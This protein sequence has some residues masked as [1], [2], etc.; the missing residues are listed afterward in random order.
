MKD[1]YEKIIIRN[2]KKIPYFLKTKPIIHLEQNNYALIGKLS[3]SLLHDILTPLTSLSLLS[4]VSKDATR[5]EP[6]ITHSTNQISEYVSILKDFLNCASDEK[7]IL[8]NSEISK[9]LTLLKH[10]ALVHNIQIQYIEFDQIQTS[11]H[12]LHIYQIIIN[13]ISNAIEASTESETKKIILSIRKFKKNFYIECRDYGTGILSED[14][15]Q[16]GLYNFSTKSKQR[17]FGLYSVTYIIQTILKG[18]LYIESEPGKGSLFSCEIP[19]T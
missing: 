5:L 11:I 19:L 4:E 13:L 12:P 7:G 3:T 17:G 15:K 6:I 1:M 16:I 9:C 18:N 8:V 2:F 10:K 14:I